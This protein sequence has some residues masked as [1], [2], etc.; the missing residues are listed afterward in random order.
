[1][2]Q[3][4]R[5]SASSLV[6]LPG[7]RDRRRL[8]PPPHLADDEQKLFTEIVASCPAEQFVASDAL[9]LAAYVQAVLLAQGAIKEAARD[10]RALAVWEK[11]TRAQTALA[12]KLRLSPQARADPR[13]LGRKPAPTS[14]YDVLLKDDADNGV[15]R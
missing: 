14:V 10:P 5:K 7:D 2:L 9:L 8:Q 6:A 3:R 15:K 1:M 12:T 4:G 11:T 13:T